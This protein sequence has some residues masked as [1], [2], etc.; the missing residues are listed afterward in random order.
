MPLELEA[1]KLNIGMILGMRK[2]VTH[3]LFRVFAI[4]WTAQQAL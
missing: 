4:Y 3:T 1:Y 2:G